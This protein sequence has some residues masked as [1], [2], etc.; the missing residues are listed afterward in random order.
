M[1]KVDYLS[2]QWIVAANAI[3]TSMTPSSKPFV[4]AYQVTNCPGEADEQTHHLVL[5][6]EQVKMARGPG[7]ANVM[8]TLPW[9]LACRI[10]QGQTGAQRAFLDGLLSIAG[11]PNAL[12]GHQQY[13][14]AVD[15]ELAQ[16]REETNFL[17]S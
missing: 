12:L 3:L 4:V 1:A 13:L 8:L 7:H 11:D 9:S 2:D 10:A 16:L 15:D 14:A 17:V 5:G 6:P